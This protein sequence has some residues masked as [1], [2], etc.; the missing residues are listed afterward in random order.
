MTRACK[1][2]IGDI[3]KERNIEIIGIAIRGRATGAP[4]LDG[5]R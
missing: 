2:A 1:G 5:R 3:L 4:S